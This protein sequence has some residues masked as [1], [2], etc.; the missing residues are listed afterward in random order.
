MK[1]AHFYILTFAFMF[2]FSSCEDNNDEKFSI[3]LNKYSLTMTINGEEEIIELKTNHEW[4]IT[5]IPEWLEVYPSSGNHSSEIS[6]KAAKN[7]D[8]ER[9]ETSLIFTS[10]ETSKELKIKQLGLSDLDPF[11]ELSD[12]DITMNVGGET[13]KIEITTNNPWEITNVPVW[14]TVYPTSGEKSTSITI[15]VYKNSDA[16][17][18]QVN[19]EVFS[20]D[21]KVKEKLLVHQYGRKEYFRS[22][23]LP[24][25]SFSRYTVTG[26]IHYNLESNSIFVNPSIKN[27]IYLGNLISH[28]AGDNTNIPE[29]TGYTFNPIT[30]STSA[31]VSG[32]IVKTYIPSLAEQNAFAK[33]IVERRPSQTESFIADNGTIEFF[34]YKQLYA[35]GITNMGIKL[36]EVV[37]GSPYTEKEMSKK[38][39]VIFSFKQ[40]LFSLIMD[41]P[42]KLIKEDLKGTDKSKGVSYVSS[43]S[44]G[45][46]GLLVVESDTDSQPIRVIINKILADETIS[47]DE[48]A[49][50][51]TADICYV[52]FNNDNQVQTVKG[53]LNAIDAYKN[54]LND[55]DNIYPVGFGLADFAD[56]SSNTIAFSFS[57]S[58]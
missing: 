29:F 10:G 12:N 11:I 32:E 6:I 22:S 33:G 53:T 45:K 37:S 44:Y 55:K 54:A 46:I 38:Y 16:D 57:L 8:L 56:H 43:V 15:V 52:Y 5:D 19:L 42:E 51:E 1:K 4:E 17:P 30:I 40:K 27:K 35:V 9:R 23:D 7:K 24:I 13:K 2:I 28:N 31:A 50:V 34:T 18:R 48:T 26:G 47:A 58:Q 21:K 14:M 39:G 3:D 36:D 20:E 25:F 49:L 41:L